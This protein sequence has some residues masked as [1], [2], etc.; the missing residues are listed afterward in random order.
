M[1]GFLIFRLIRKQDLEYIFQW[2]EPNDYLRSGVLERYVSEGKAY[3]V[4]IDGK[5]VA[6]GI[7][8]VVGEE[9]AWLMGA[10]VMKEHRGHGVGSHLTQGLIEEASRSGLRW[11]ALLTS[12]DNKPVHRICE[13]LS[14]QKRALISWMHMDKDKI[15]RLGEGGVYISVPST[16]RKAMDHI[17]RSIGN[18]NLMIP[19][20]D[21]MWVWRP[22][23][24][25]AIER[26]I[27]ASER[28]CL[29]RDGGFGV[30]ALIRFRRDRGTLQAL[31]LE[32]QKTMGSVNDIAGCIAYE[33]VQDRFGEIELVVVEGPGQ[34][35]SVWE[36]IYQLAREKPWRAYVFYK[37]L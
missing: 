12:V 9:G 31:V 21:N 25:E 2:L 28:L 20:S 3:T 13:K 1:G 4:E 7:I 18:S 24:G 5:P 17:K 16:D 6:V 36:S 23:S 26:M 15:Y 22:P 27:L 29:A 34:E 11:V 8:H 37:E 19:D 33:S 14:L 10:R 30:I 32:T 35:Q